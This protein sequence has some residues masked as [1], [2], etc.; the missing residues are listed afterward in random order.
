MSFKTGS[1]WTQTSSQDPFPVVM[2]IKFDCIPETQNIHHNKPPSRHSIP[3]ILFASMQL[4]K[5]KHVSCTA[6]VVHI[7]PLGRQ[8]LAG[9][10][11]G[12]AFEKIWTCIKGSVLAQKPVGL[13]NDG[14]PRVLLSEDWKESKTGKLAPCLDLNL[15]GT[16]KKNLEAGGFSALTQNGR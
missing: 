4:A 1:F 13:S 9:R 3:W 14:A 16:Q 7:K 10:V 2:T 6:S 12:L 15:R 11:W 8:T 5:P